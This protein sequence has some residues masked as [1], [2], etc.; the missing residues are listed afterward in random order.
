MWKSHHSWLASL[1]LFFLS[2]GTLAVNVSDGFSPEANNTVRA[3]E[4]QPHG[5]IVVGGHFT[6]IDGQMRERIARVNADGSLNMALNP[7]ANQSVSALALLAAGKL[8]VGGAFSMIG[9]EPRGYQRGLVAGQAIADTLEYA[10]YSNAVSDIRWMRSGS[11]PQF[12]RNPQRELSLNGTPYGLIDSMQPLDVGWRYQGYNARRSLC[13][14]FER[15]ARRALVPTTAQIASSRKSASVRPA[16]TT[17][18]S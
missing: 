2:A 18:F 3:L 10:G 13:S 11:A 4:V 8:V 1:A 9:G 6:T 5:K 16:T 12:K 14:T 17:A 7:S 15:L